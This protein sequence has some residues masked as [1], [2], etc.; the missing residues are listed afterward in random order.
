MVDALEAEFERLALGIDQ[1]LYYDGFRL[2]FRRTF[3]VE[4]YKEGGEFVVNPSSR[5]AVSAP[6]RMNAAILE[7]EIEIVEQGRG[8][9]FAPKPQLHLFKVGES[10]VVE[11]KVGESES[12]STTKVESGLRKK[13]VKKNK[14]ARVAN[15]K[16]EAKKRATQSEADSHQAAH[17]W[18]EEWARHLPEAVKFKWGP[19]DLDDARAMWFG[20]GCKCSWEKLRMELGLPRLDDDD[21]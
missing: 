5:R 4:V 19:E 7:T 15:Q 11:S 8:V 6:P 9:A 14:A 1:T 2:E 13:K 18:T 20:L 21:E 16:K 3:L 17:Q 12:C 10:E